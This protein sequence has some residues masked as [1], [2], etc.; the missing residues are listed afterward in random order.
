MPRPDDVAALREIANLGALH[1]LVEISTTQL[2]TL[3]GLSQQSASRRVVELEQA[4]YIRRE[5]GVRRQLVRL[6]EEGVNVLSR[7]YAAYKQMFEHRDRLRIRGRI[8]SGLGEG[9]YY[10][11][12]KQYVEQFRQKLGF[13]PYPGTLN[14]QVE[15]AETNKLRILKASPA[16]LIEGFQDQDRTFGAVDAW[17]ADLRSIHCALILPHRTHHARTVELVAPVH[18]RE[19][20]KLKDGDEVDVGVLL[21]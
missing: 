15:G 21:S 4:G 13:E 8:A 6:T 1:G 10:L 11:S 20:L 18:L 14:L 2:A 5:M 12:Q 16:L 17:R 3:L 7:E 19:K 9:R